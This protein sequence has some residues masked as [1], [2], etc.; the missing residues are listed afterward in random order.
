VVRAV[1]TACSGSL[2]APPKTAGWFRHS[3]TLEVVRQTSASGHAKA[4]SQMRQC[5]SYAVSFAPAKI[6]MRFTT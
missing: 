3:L 2:R 6:A 4:L 1:R 5:G